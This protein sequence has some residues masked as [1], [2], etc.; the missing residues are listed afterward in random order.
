VKT[1]DLG[2]L[3]GGFGV[4]VSVKIMTDSF[5]GDSLGYAYV[6]MESFDQALMALDCLNNTPFQG[7]LIVVEKTNE[8][9]SSKPV[10]FVNAFVCDLRTAN[11]KA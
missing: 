2:D 3:F 6:E 4:V 5:T 1:A 11:S 10:A 7:R 9:E 8:D